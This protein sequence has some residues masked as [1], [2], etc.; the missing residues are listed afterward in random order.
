LESVKD[1]AAV[2]SFTK[3]FMSAFELYCVLPYRKRVLES[4]MDKISRAADIVQAMESAAKAEREKAKAKNR[5]LGII[6]GSKRA[7]VE[8]SATARKVSRRKSPTGR[9]VTDMLLD[10][11]K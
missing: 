5:M 4:T 8:S 1:K 2:D 7:R 11:A 10:V 6:S 9:A 3:P